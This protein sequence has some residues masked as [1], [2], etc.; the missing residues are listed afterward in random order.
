M[1]CQCYCNEAQEEH[2]HCSECGCVLTSHESEEHCRWCEERIQRE[3]LA[4][5]RG[6]ADAYYGKRAPVPHIWLDDLGKEIVYTQHMTEEERKAY[7]KGYD[8]QIDRK[9]WD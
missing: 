5:K 7:W 1:T 6:A 2:D 8:E 4:L 9:E 3:K